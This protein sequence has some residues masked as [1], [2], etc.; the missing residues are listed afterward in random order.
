LIDA[1]V[2]R[3]KLPRA[4]AASAVDAT[5]KAIFAALR[6]SGAPAGRRGQDCGLRQLPRGKTCGA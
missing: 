5:F 2:M 3:T 1:V 6:R 4:T